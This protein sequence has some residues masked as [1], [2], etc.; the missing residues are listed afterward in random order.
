MSKP[1]NLQKFYDHFTSDLSEQSV[2][3]NPKLIR[4]RDTYF[5]CLENF[6]MPDHKIVSYLMETYGLSQSQAYRDIADM[7]WFMSKMQN[8]GRNHAQYIVNQTLLEAIELTK[9]NKKLV[10]AN[11]M[12][13]DKFGKYNN[14]DKPEELDIP[15]NEIIPIP[16]MFT[17]DPTYLDVEYLTPAERKKEKAALYKKYGD[18][19]EVIDTPYI[20]VINERNE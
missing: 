19:I 2:A 20:E 4:Y 10:I 12:A 9:G 3:D 13:A 15:W 5:H 16:I 8:I 1:T 18:D 17:D 11:I 6:A 14:L 7:R